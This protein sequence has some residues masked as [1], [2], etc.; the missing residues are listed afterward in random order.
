RHAAGVQVRSCEPG[1][2]RWT[3]FPHAEERGRFL[4]VAS[5]D[6]AVVVDQLGDAVGLDKASID[7]T[8]PPRGRAV[9]DPLRRLSLYMGRRVVPENA[10]LLSVRIPAAGRIRLLRVG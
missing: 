2:R 6:G 8:D 1:A 4:A 3:E 9:R 10:A 5:Q 7:G